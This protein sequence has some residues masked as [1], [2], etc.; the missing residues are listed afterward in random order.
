MCFLGD[1][2]ISRMSRMSSYCKNLSCA[3]Q[4][5]GGIDQCAS[6]LQSSMTKLKDTMEQGHARP[7]TS[8]DERAACIAKLTAEIESAPPSRFIDFNLIAKIYQLK[9]LRGDGQE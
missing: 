2:P 3:N 9:V 4:S 6:C 1:F 8:A 5:S 7:T